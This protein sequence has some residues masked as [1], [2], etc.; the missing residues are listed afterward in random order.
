MTSQDIE[1]ATAATTTSDD[2]LE[3]LAS[4]HGVILASLVQDGPCTFRDLQ[5]RVSTRCAERNAYLPSRGA[6]FEFD[7]HSLLMEGLVEVH[8]GQV[9]ASQ[10]VDAV[11]GTRSMSQSH[12]P[13]RQH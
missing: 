6:R 10:I 4:Y 12:P 3:D 9:R 5:A 1:R 11:V 13:R 7:V 8:E 2:D